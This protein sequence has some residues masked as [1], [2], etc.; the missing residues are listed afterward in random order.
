MLMSFHINNVLSFCLSFSLLTPSLSQLAKGLIEDCPFT[1]ET[2]ID[3]NIGTLQITSLSI[4]LLTLSV[5]SLVCCRMGAQAG[6]TRLTVAEE[7]E[8]PP[9]TLPR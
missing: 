5:I 7:E 1:F 3:N 8:K 9:E 2:I 4:C 6:R